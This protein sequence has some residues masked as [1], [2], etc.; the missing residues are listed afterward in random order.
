MKKIFIIIIIILGSIIFKIPEYVE[1][2]DLAII[3][4]MAVEYKDSRYTVYLKEIIPKKDENGINYDYK[5]Y[6]A[7]DIDLDDVYKKLKAKTKKKLYYKSVK[8]LII[9]LEKSD[10]IVKI[11]SINPKNI[12]HTKKDLYKELKKS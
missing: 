2:N 5:Y 6:N 12:I 7:S 3:E 4:N 9:N 10:E 11:F 8:S 1:L